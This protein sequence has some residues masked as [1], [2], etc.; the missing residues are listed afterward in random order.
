MICMTFNILLIMGVHIM[1][2][3]FI[4]VIRSKLFQVLI[5]ASA[6]NS[7]IL[8]HASKPFQMSLLVHWQSIP[9]LLYCVYF[10][11][12]S[13]LLFYNIRMTIWKKLL[14]KPSTNVNF[15]AWVCFDSLSFCYLLSI[16]NGLSHKIH[17]AL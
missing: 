4:A 9:I 3:P 11:Q 10:H 16:E 7:V 14:I 12:S 2:I 8:N 17:L 1:I 13:S 6:M 5:I 15:Y